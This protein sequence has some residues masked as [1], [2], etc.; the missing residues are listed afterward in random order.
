MKIFASM[1]RTHRRLFVVAASVAMDLCVVGLVLGMFT[2]GGI[3]TAIGLEGQLE[4]LDPTPG[5]MILFC[6]GGLICLAAGCAVGFMGLSN[7]L[8]KATTM[9]TVR[10]STIRSFPCDG[11]MEH[12]V[13]STVSYYV[14]GVAYENEGRRQFSS[15]DMEAAKKALAGTNPGDQVR[16][17][18]KPGDPGVIDLDAPPIDKSGSIAFG[19]ALVV[20]AMILFFTAG[21]MIQQLNA[22]TK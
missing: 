2:G 18:Y 11:G 13:F 21:C 1:S 7:A 15:N 22:L 10:S 16:V 12:Y 14:D 3:L 4:L 20:V 9:G 5:T 17:F 19:V 6:L 8:M